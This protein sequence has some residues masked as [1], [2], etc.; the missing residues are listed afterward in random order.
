MQSANCHEPISRSELAS[1][2]GIA[3]GLLLDPN[4]I[5]NKIMTQITTIFQRYCDEWADELTAD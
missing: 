4:E 3:I 5:D 1:A 2:L